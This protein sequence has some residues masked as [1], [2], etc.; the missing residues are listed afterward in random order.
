M[1]NNVSVSVI[2]PVYNTEQ[3]IKKCV[4]SILNQ[5]YTDFELI[6]SDDGST[7]GS[8][9]LC[10]KFEQQDK[11]VKYIRQENKGAG[12]ARNSGIDA[13]SGMYITFVDSDD[14]LDEDYLEML[15]QAAKDCDI[16]QI[17]NHVYSPEGDVNRGDGINETLL[18]EMDGRS[19]SR[20]LLEGKYRAGGVPWAKLYRRSLWEDVRFPNMK[21][22]EDVAVLYKI[23]WKADKMRN[24]ACA[25]YCYRSQRP[26]S[27]M[28]SPYSLEWL[29]ILDVEREKMEFYRQK[30]DYTLYVLT[31]FELI[32]QLQSNI[33][34]VKKYLPEEKKT[35]AW[36]KKSLRREV[37]KQLG[38]KGFAKKKIKAVLVAVRYG[39]M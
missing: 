3:Y 18:D 7:D 9:E 31:R 38:E 27:I 2:V 1:N 8:P 30:G 32:N 4:E 19:V 21:R 28:H 22:F 37:W 36:L 16:V 20:Y 5:T 23:Y 12:A 34:K 24:I 13:S 11:R 15:V 39:I 25:K 17:G 29:E 26:G 35:L 33:V 6:L 10:R 14:W